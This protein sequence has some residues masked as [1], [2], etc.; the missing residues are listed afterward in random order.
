MAAGTVTIFDEAILAINNGVHDFDTDVFK[1]AWINNDTVPSAG[2]L[3]PT[4]SDFSTGEQLGGT[5]PL[6]GGETISITAANVAGTTTITPTT[7]VSHIKDPANPTAVFWALLYN[8]SKTNQ[9][10]AF[11]EIAAAGA[12]GTLGLISLTWGANL[13]T[14]TQ[15]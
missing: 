9:A 8:S 14:M 7:N 5:F 11:I 12:D 10:V 1:L 2:T 13:Y 15:T 3:S 6:T 4:F